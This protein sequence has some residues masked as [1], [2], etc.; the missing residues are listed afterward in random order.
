MSTKTHTAEGLTT[1]DD[2][3]VSWRSEQLRACGFDPELAGSIARDCRYDLHS[4]L[5]LVEHGCRPDL[6]ARILAPLLG[7]AKPC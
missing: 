5:E 4:L 6:A 7:E 1:E 2:E 3:V